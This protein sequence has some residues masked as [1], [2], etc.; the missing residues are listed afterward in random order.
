MPT[1]IIL[2][3]VTAAGYFDLRW[4]RIPNW[5]VAL[6]LALSLAWHTAQG[7]LSGL[8]ISVASLLGAAAVLFPLFAMRGMGAGDVK[9]FGA[10]GAAVTYRNVFG[11]LF[12]AL[13]VSGLMALFKV[14]RA[15]SLGQTVARIGHLLGRWVRGRVTPHPVVNID[16]PGATVVPFTLAV[17]IATWIFLLASRS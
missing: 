3:C 6:T 4:R 7:G 5:L 17:C 12:I 1:V 2:L 13:L 15:R 8:W 16:S 10:L 9:F 14:L 11:I